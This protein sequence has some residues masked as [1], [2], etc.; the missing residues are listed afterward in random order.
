M[1]TQ[2]DNDMKHLHPVYR[3]KAAE[4]L[5]KLKDEGLP[6][7]VFEGFRSPERQR[8]LFEQGRTRPGGRVTNARAW[9]SYHQYGV[10]ADFVLYE[11][12]Q[13]SWDDSGA[14]RSWW[15]RLHELG[16]QVGLEPLSWELPHLQLQGLR[17]GA[18][19]AGDY[20]PDGDLDWASNLE[21][22]IYAWS[23]TPHAPPVP[24]II[25]DRPVLTGVTGGPL[26]FSSVPPPGTADWH[27]QFGGREWRYDPDGVY[28][29][30]FADGDAPLRTRGE[31]ITCRKIMELC[32][33]EIF[34]AA[35]KH[36][37]PMALIIMTIATETGMYRK[38]GFTGPFTFRWEPGV[39]VKDVSPPL[40]GDYSAGPMQTLGTTT[41]WLIKV[42]G[43]NYDAFRVA[44]V[45][46]RRPEPPEDHPLY[47][48]QTSID[49]GTAAIKQQWSKTGDDPILVAATYNAGGIYRSAQNPW[50]LKSYG[51]HLDR[52]AKWYGD[53]CAVLKEWQ[54]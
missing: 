20:P 1:S 47:D 53:A 6:F 26:D 48:Y 39:Q 54:A 35:K 19:Q 3:Q 44:P 40:W 37:I 33:N 13:W 38:Y 27:N 7:R 31:P 12:D 16:R 21:A 32:G 11:N 49:I 25:K 4:L 23:G 8:Y 41:R 45:Y 17:L 10:A 22:A 15:K 2:R 34:E 9:Q 28:I 5:A 30:D 24:E 36:R 51:D 46:E 43:L 18:L 50:R 42:Q 29:P 14:K 52:A